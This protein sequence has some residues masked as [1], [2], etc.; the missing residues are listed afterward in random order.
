MSTINGDLS[1]TLFAQN[2]AIVSSTFSKVALHEQWRG[3]RARSPC[4]GISFVSFSLCLF[5]QRK[6]AK[7][8]WYQRSFNAFSF[9]KIAPKEK[10]LQKE[11]GRFFA[12]TPRR[13]SLLKKLRKTFLSRLV[14]AN[15][16]RD[17]SKFAQ[18]LKNLFNFVKIYDILI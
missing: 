15:K 5:W 4:Y 16:V 9:E 12:L 10:A 13:R 1:R 11:N 6:A 14:C 8:F 17:K 2:Q 18:I 3:S 7:N